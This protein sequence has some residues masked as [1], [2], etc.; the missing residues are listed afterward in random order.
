MFFT[1]QWIPIKGADYPGVFAL[2]CGGTKPTQV[3]SWDTADATIRDKSPLSFTYGDHD[4][5]LPDI[6]EAIT[7]LGTKGFGIHE[8]VIPNA[9]HCEFDGHG[10]AMSIWNAAP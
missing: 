4:D 1:D 10:E 7:D 8:K 3:F 2:M 9:G 5:L 6:Q